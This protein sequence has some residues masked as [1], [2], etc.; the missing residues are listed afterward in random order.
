MRVCVLQAAN[1]VV[2]VWSVRQGKQQQQQV[3]QGR[4]EGRGQCPRMS[5]ADVLGAFRTDAEAIA[6]YG[7]L[8]EAQ[9][10][11]QNGMRRDHMRLG[12]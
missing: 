4:W 2:V 6:A 10:V 5:T 12:T 7:G 1:R 3:L 11:L 9:S 8:C